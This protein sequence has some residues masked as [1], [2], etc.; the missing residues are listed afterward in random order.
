MS[1]PRHD[2]I[3]CAEGQRLSGRC[4]DVTTVTGTHR[5]T[6]TTRLTDTASA[7]VIDTSS[8]NIFG[9][10]QLLVLTRS[11]DIYQYIPYI[12]QYRKDTYLIPISFKSWSVRE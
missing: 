11:D 3:E 5:L 6:T 10:L 9:N 7:T 4:G 1:M 12:Y 2:N 8:L